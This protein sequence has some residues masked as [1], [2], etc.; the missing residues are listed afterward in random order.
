MN[1]VLM[2]SLLWLVACGSVDSGVAPDAPAIVEAPEITFEAADIDATEEGPYVVLAGPYVVIEL[3][4]ILE[5]ATY[6]EASYTAPEFTLQDSGAPAHGDVMEDDGEIL[7]VADEGY[8]G[9][10]TFTYALSIT[11]QETGAVLSRAA[12]ITV[13]VQE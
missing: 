2:S 3:T 9:E 13:D 10:D 11:N 1:K 5:E 4:Y 7:Y 6:P 8:L 12:T